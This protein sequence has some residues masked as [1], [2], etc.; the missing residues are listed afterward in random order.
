MSLCKKCNC[1]WA[2]WQVLSEFIDWRYSRSCWYFRHVKNLLVNRLSG[3]CLSEFI[4]LGIQSV[5][6]VFCDPALWTVAPLTFSLVQFWRVEPPSLCHSVYRQCVAGRGW[7]YWVLLETIFCRSLTLCIWPDSEPTKLPDHPKQ[8]PRR[9]EGLRQINTC[10]TVTLQVK[11]FDEE[12]LLWCL[13][14]ISYTVYITV[15]NN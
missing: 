4:R 8:K 5:M 13:Y 9:G 6:L 14:S 2:F 1:K 3:R 10:R 12:I 15:E 11:F 7:V